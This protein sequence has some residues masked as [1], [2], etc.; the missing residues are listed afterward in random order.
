MLLCDYIDKQLKDGF[1]TS[2]EVSEDIIHNL[3][4]KFEMRDYQKEALENFILY[5]EDTRLNHNAQIHLLFQLATGSGKTYIMA[6]CILYL[7]KQ[8][9]RNF[10]F[11]VDSKNIIDKTKMNFLDKSSSKYLFADSIMIDGKEVEIIEVE[12]FQT[13]DSDAINIKFTTIQKLATDL[14]TVKENKISKFD[15]MHHKIAILSDEAHHMNAETKRGKGEAL[16]AEEYEEI[17]SWEKAGDYALR[18]NKNNILLEFTATM[19]LKDSYIL[20]KYKDKVIYNYPLM[21][22]REDGF[23][24]DFFNLQNNYNALERTLLAMLLSQYR[25]KLFQDIGKNVKPTILLK[26]STIPLAKDFHK[27]FNEYIQ[28][29][30]E[31]SDIDKYRNTEN[32]LILKMFEYFDKKNISSQDLVQELKLDFP[33]EK[34]LLLHS[35]VSNKEMQDLQI[36]VNT[37]EEKDNPIRMIFTVDM[38]HEGWDVLNLYDIVRLYETRQS[39]KKIANTTIQEAQ[40]IGRGVRYYPFII[41]DQAENQY[42][43]KWDYDPENPMRICETLLYHSVDDSRYITELRQALQ[44]TGFEADN[45]V[46]FIYKLKIDFE[47]TDTY[48]NGKLFINKRVPEDREQINSLP[49]NFKED[50][51]YD[52]SNRGINIFGLADNS[53]IKETKEF[54]NERYDYL[55]KD[56]DKRLIYKALRCFNVLSFNQLQKYF[57]NLKSIDEFI[58][59]NDYLG[60]YTFHI[61]KSGKVTNLDKVAALKILFEKLSYKIKGIKNSYRGTNEFNEVPLNSYIKTTIRHKNNP[62]LEG[63]GISQ[64]SPTVNAEYRL[65]LSTKDWFVYTDNYG[66]TEE[67]RFVKFFDEMANKLSK[68][69]DHVYLLRNERNLHIYSFKNGLR[70]EPDYILLLRND[71]YNYF[72]EQQIFI[73]PKGEIYRENDRWKEEFL[74]EMENTARAI[75]YVDSD[76]YKIIGL[77]FYTHN[78]EDDRFTETFIEKTDIKNH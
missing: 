22:F 78:V 23:T 29:D 5:Q 68:K 11:F 18:S 63:E 48:K 14:K 54:E 30:I 7:Y 50:I 71:K 56:I 72:E 70:F 26:H 65:D 64:N 28:K 10:L 66:T 40:L 4:D 51:R 38:L 9:F 36:K 3:A 43:R 6:S 15:F 45:T 17:N 52:I 73:E 39:G 75:T 59:S 2:K 41:E 55:L 34:T 35:K 74:L 24:K 69:Y 20:T 19:D 62:D 61:I 58:T 32:E 37:L 76:K 49:G 46:E 27:S 60:N 21:S 57:P 33:E 13:T 77:P 16:T 47:M 8:G 31:D 12:N 67:K 1:I 42:K 44:Q 25:L 53:F